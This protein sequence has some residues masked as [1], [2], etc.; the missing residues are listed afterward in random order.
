MSPTPVPEEPKTSRARGKPAFIALGVLA[1][2]VV[3]GIGAYAYFTAGRESTDDAV[4]EAD[5]VPVASRVSGVI[6]S[7]LVHDNQTVKKGDPLLV[8]DAADFAARLAQA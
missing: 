6:A 8:L 2:V 1:L 4:I 5:V 3:G 7:V